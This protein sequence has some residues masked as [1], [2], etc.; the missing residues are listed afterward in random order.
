MRVTGVR[1]SKHPRVWASASGGSSGFRCAGDRPRG[2]RARFRRSRTTSGTIFLIP[3]RRGRCSSSTRVGAGDCVCRRAIEP[4]GRR[5]RTLSWWPAAGSGGAAGE[6]IARLWR[7]SVAV[8]IA[9]RLAGARCRRPRSR[10]GRPRGL[11]LP[12]R[13]LGRRGR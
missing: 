3:A 6:M 13:M 5:S 1:S 4:I 11:A 8:S 7:H 2:S 12:P 9:A 10:G